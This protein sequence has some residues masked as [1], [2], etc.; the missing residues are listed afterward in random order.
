MLDIIFVGILILS[1]LAYGF[2]QYFAR[3][4]NAREKRKNEAQYKK[5]DEYAPKDSKSNL[6]KKSDKNQSCK[7][8]IVKN[9]KRSNLK[10]RSDKTNYSHD[11]LLT[12]LKGHTGSVLDMSF[13]SNGKYLATCADDSKSMLQTIDVESDVTNETSTSSEDS[14]KQKRTQRNRKTTHQ[15]FVKQR[16]TRSN[17]Q[18]GK[19]M[20]HHS[21]QVQTIRSPHKNENQGYRAL[22][23]PL[24]QH[25]KLNLNDAQLV[26]YLKNYLLDETL[27]RLLGFPIEY[28]VAPNLAI[29]YKYPPYEFISQRKQSLASST[30][31]Y[32]NN[33]P[34]IVNDND[35]LTPE[36]ENFGSEINDSDSGQ[37]SGSS[38]PSEDFEINQTRPAAA[39]GSLPPHYM[40]MIGS[41]KE[42]TR[43][44]KGFYVTNGGDYVTQE[45]CLYHWGKVNRFYDGPMMRHIYSCCN[46]DYDANLMNGCTANRVH[47]W[48]GVSPGLNGPYEGFIRTKRRPGS[49]PEDGNTGI[50]ALDCEMC[51]TGCGLELT[52]VSIIRS[53]GNLFY[54]SFVRP[55]R[56]IVDYNTRYSGITEKD[57]N[58]TTS[59]WN[60]SNN[61]RRASTASNSSSSSTGSNNGHT[62]TVKT[63]KEVQKDL[64]KFIFDDT[65]LIGHSIENDLKALKLIHKTIID[66]SITFPHFYGLPYRRSLKTLTKSILKRDIQQNSTGHCSFED[67]RAC[68]ELLLWKVRKDFRAVLEQ[69]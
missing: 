13:S 40:S 10:K 42:C 47:V 24:R 46:R 32:Y 33:D 5:F 62:K 43:C 34:I 14:P 19:I 41:Q 56:D 4:K 53:D 61:M 15:H 11:W 38:S 23:P 39:S 3:P 36:K 59:S 20:S 12:T 18:G 50:Y 29:I 57:L 68:L 9:P 49:P 7:T 37:G 44:G 1:A 54:E 8:N 22:E 60:H 66:T 6:S 27:M 45:P 28:D 31:T 17:N 16:T 2:W 35:G 63:L 69:N 67:S 30:T 58:T 52:K 25:I 51:F 48:T 65:I 26:Q 21:V 64:L 55:D